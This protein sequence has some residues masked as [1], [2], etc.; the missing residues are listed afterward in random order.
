MRFGPRWKSEGMDEILDEAFALTNQIFI[1]EFGSDARVH[2]WGE[3]GFT[4]D[5]EAQAHYLR[6]LT[7]RIRDYSAQTYREIQGIFCWS[8]QRIQMEWENGLECRLALINPEVDKNRRMTSWHP[9][10]ASQYLKE[11]YKDE[12]AQAKNL[13]A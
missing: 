3:S 6:E 13:I 7:E 5:D 12:P 4:F 10:P 2:R 8:D 11:V 9:T 1:T